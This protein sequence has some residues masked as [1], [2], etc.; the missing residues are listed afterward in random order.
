MKFIKHL[1]I[2]PKN[3]IPVA[4]FIVDVNPNFLTIGKTNNEVITFPI[5]NIVELQTTE[6]E[7]TS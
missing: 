5:R 6:L 2:V 1:I 7:A 4:S 3:E